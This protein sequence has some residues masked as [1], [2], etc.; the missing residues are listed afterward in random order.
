VYD[1]SDRIVCADW[2]Q[3]IAFSPCQHQCMTPECV[4]DVAQC[5]DRKRVHLSSCFR[6][7]NTDGMLCRDLGQQVA[8]LLGCTACP[9]STHPAGFCLN[10]RCSIHKSSHML[11]RDL[12]KRVA[13][14]LGCT[15][16]SGG[17]PGMMEAATLGV[18][19]HI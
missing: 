2:P 12:G 4:Q 11:S 8:Q 14:L 3:H 19:P 13:Q 18:P 15:T 7:L 1:N 5:V 16:W 9:G 10:T 17:G 6:L